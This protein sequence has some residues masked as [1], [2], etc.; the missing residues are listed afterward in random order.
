MELTELSLFSEPELKN[1]YSVSY[2]E[3]EQGRLKV[4]HAIKALGAR[5]T[6]EEYPSLRAQ[7]VLLKRCHEEFIPKHQSICSKL[8]KVGVGTSKMREWRREC[9]QEMG[10]PVVRMKHMAHLSLPAVAVAVNGVVA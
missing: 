2:M 3:L 10:I 4:V 9:R 1:L 5:P 6:K 7:L 8:H